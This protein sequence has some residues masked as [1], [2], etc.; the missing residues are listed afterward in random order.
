[1]YL[2]HTL[3]IER[4]PPAGEN[5]KWRKIIISGGWAKAFFFFA[6]GKGTGTKM[7][8]VAYRE[9]YM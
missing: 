4:V 6:G 3:C 7:N 9:I 8:Y 1:M 5:K 2:I